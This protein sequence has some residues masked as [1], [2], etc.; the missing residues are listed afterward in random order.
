MFVKE[1]IKRKKFK[2]TCKNP[3]YSN[4]NLREHSK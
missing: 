4:E 1:E 2:R 3:Q